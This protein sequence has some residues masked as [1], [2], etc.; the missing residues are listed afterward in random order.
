[1]A[2][3]DARPHIPESRMDAFEDRRADADWLFD[4]GNAALCLQYIRAPEGRSGLRKTW[5]RLPSSNLPPS[6]S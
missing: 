2:S 4:G 1:M 5:T 3:G 6:E